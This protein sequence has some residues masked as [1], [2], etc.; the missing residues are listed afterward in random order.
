MSINLNF[1]ILWSV[2]DK[3]QAEAPSQYRQRLGKQHR[4]P[5]MLFDKT[6]RLAPIV[7]KSSVGGS[8]VLRPSTG[9]AGNLLQFFELD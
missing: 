3:R 1:P 8:V 4:I 6:A 7:H 9:G 2:I 5:L